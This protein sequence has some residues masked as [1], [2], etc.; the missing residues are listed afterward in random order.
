MMLVPYQLT[1]MKHCTILISFIA[2]A[3]LEY[4]I[5]ALPLSQDFIRMQF[6]KDHQEIKD[7][8]HR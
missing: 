7:L 1:N 6:E 3:V 2:I 4:G 5:L 8:C